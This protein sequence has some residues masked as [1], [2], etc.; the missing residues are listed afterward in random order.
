MPEGL[1]AL[2]ILLLPIGLVAVAAAGAG[3][4][5]ALDARGRGARLGLGGAIRS[6]TARLMLQRRRTL[7]GAD[8]LLWRIGGGGLA[9]VAV[10]MVAVIPFGGLVFVDLPVG[11]VWFNAMD[12]M[13][14]ALW[15]LL[16]WGANSTFALVG[17]YRFLAQAL[18][19]EIPLMFALSTPA[20]AAGS[21]RLTDIVSAQS[22]LWF[23]VWMPAAFVVFV[24]SIAAFSS[25]G[26]FATASAPDVA[27]GVLA[28][29]SGPDR[30]VV[31]AGRW[32]LL[33]AGAAFAV[34]MFLGGG[35]GPFLPEWLWVVVKTVLVLGVIIGA[36]RL[37]PVIR[38]QQL[39]E[40]GWVVVLP[41]VLVQ[42]LIVS[43]LVASGVA[44]VTSALP[45]VAGLVTLAG[46]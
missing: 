33:A 32:M 26:P 44:P 14:W 18:A 27:G 37:L 23:V 21:L 17:G 40:V 28:E 19:Y 5:T 1:A 16:G 7:P 22:E 41:L 13:L 11:V 42:L 20:V 46:A 43:I 8:S 15:W 24:I 2:A 39:V 38:P 30:L 35:A 34:P 25:W 10:L 29:L 3:L 36:R 4:S 9:V 45:A 31:L 6:E 12:V